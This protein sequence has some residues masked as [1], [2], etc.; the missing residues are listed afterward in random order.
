MPRPYPC[1]GTRLWAVVG[2][3][4]V[5]TVWSSPAQADLPRALHDLTHVTPSAPLR[6][7]L[8][9]VAGSSTVE[10]RARSRRCAKATPVTLLISVDARRIARV[11]L[12]SANWRNVS[13]PQKLAAGGH[14]LLVGVAGRPACSRATVDELRLGG[15]ADRPADAP[16]PPGT[17]LGPK[18]RIPIGA[19]V[20][21]D[22]STRLDRAEDQAFL[23]HFQ[24][25]TPENAMKMTYVEPRRNEFDWSETDPLVTYAMD[26]HRTV[27]GHTLI[28]HKQLPGWLTQRRW[29]REEMTAVMKEWISGIAGRYK[30]RITDWDVLNELFDEHG[31]WRT[32]SPW[33]DALGPDLADMALRTASEVDPG[34]R[35]FINDFDIELPGPKQDAVYNLARDLKAR[36]VPLDGI[37]IQAHWSGESLPPEPTLLATMNRFASLGL[38]V[39]L[40]ELDITTDRFADAL[41]RQADAYAMAGRVCQ[42]VAS[43][44]RI[45]VWGISDKDSW[46]G[47][48]NRPLLFDDKFNAK[49]AYGALI[50][51]LAAG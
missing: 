11:K 13:V 34:A 9:T 10:L 30:G 39:E 19:A 49:P 37:G 40:T 17:P 22:I 2:A 3:V 26:Q 38:R 51:A 36:G 31:A 15:R 18:R 42:S 1:F 41:Q 27:R 46:R 50:G 21:W 24:G 28:W 7:T 44:D 33:Y 8:G 23:G 20:N 14:T 45:T 6:A 4:A 29:T 12:H 32:N 47:G 43:C 25:L 16:A 5:A 35:L 48:V